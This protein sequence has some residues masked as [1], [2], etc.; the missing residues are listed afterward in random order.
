MRLRSHLEQATDLIK[1]SKPVGRTLDFLCQ[2][3]LRE[4]HTV[5]AKAA[6][7]DVHGEVLA[8]RREIEKIRQ[9]VQNIE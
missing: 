9:Q 7:L 3:M 8:L 5:A 1:S 2:E 6:D 4:T